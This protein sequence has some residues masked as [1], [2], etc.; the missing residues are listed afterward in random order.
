MKAVV[1]RA[2]AAALASAVLAGMMSCAA[3]TAARTAT[4]MSAHA[5]WQLVKQVRTGSYGG[6]TAIVAVGPR[7]GWAFDG[8]SAPT[9]WERSGSSWTRVPFPGLAGEEV[10]AAGASS[11]SDVW[12]FTD[13]SH[14]RVLRWDGRAWSVQR[15]FPGQ[16]DGGIVIGRADVW[17]FGQSYQSMG[18]LGAWHYNGT[19]W[20]RVAS[21]H[22]LDGG[23]A[24]SA[25]D[26]WAFGGTNVAHWDG[27]TWTR[28]SVT[29]LLPP[30][31]PLNFPGVRGI[32]ALSDHNV[33]AI[34]SGN[35][36]D[37]GGPSVILHYDGHSWTKTAGGYYGIG[38]EPIQ[39]VSPDGRGGLWLPMPGVDGMPSYLVHYT[40]GHLVTVTLPRQATAID[41]ECT[42]LIR[43]S[44]SLL[45]G[46]LTYASGNPGTNVAA[47]IYQYTP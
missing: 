28:T 10:I 31:Q 19:A 25:R 43:G 6:F 37:E 15:S 30:R 18:G 47:V 41:I 17:V 36:Q 8:F 22:G 26:I 20:S 11:P 7:S 14:S 27:S 40:S 42:A 45:A 12:A 1:W 23:S 13:G 33:Y 3:T 34:G 21:G 38:T 24:L 9:A 29:G 32:L 4:A 46:G 35:A 39:Q 44:T 16:I 5:S 2:G